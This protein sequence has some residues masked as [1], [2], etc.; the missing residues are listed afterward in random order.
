[1]LNPAP[2][3]GAGGRALDR[4]KASIL[5]AIVREYV[6]TGQPV[7]SKT[8]ADRYRL[9]VSAAT[10]RNDM[11]VLEELGYIVQPHTS[12]GRIP[13]DLGYRWFV[14]NW[15]GAAWPNIPETERRAIDLV[16][17]SEARG[18]ES[19][20]DSTSQVLSKL[21]EAAG[22][23]LAPP[24][25]KN[26]LRRLELL[27]RDPRRATVLLIARSGEVEQGLV[28]FAADRSEDDLD[29][30]AKSLNTK[31]DGIEFSKLASTILESPAVTED[32]KVVAAEI[33]DVL[34][35]RASQRIFRGGTANILSSRYF[36]D[37]ETVHEIVDALEHPM[38]LSGML[39]AASGAATLL[40]FIGQEVPVEQMRSCAVIFSPYEAGSDRQ[41]SIGVIGPTR[42]DYPH[43]IAAVEA[44]ARRLS[45]LLEAEG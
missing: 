28:E 25:R 11:G 6:K 36:S 10:I 22:I 41:G 19:V 39:T 34:V 13:T 8:L 16:L 18:L 7:A 26:L 15:P 9:Q 2:L 20:L 29:L 37:L 40:V 31:L 4:R 38:I 5:R 3:P 30:L 1:M 21:T 17:S 24:S 42:M 14:D 45:V 12:A 35:E 33:K 23:A 43:T 32:E 27:S 44:V